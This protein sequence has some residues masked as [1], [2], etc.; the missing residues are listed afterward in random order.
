M[1]PHFPH[2]KQV[3]T[4]WLA[5]DVPFVLGCLSLQF[6]L[7]VRTRQFPLTWEIPRH[8]IRLLRSRRSKPM[9]CPI[10]PIF[11]LEDT[12]GIVTLKKL[13]RRLLRFLLSINFFKV[14]VCK[15]KTAFKKHMPKRMP[16]LCSASNNSYDE[17]KAIRLRCIHYLS[18]PYPC[19]FSQFILA[20]E[21]DARFDQFNLLPQ[22][23]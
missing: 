10:P 5:S 13:Y 16:N 23:N 20:L 19:N 15:C 17:V 8:H 6:A 1:K 9:G 14:L 18:Y 21:S 4:V 22:K 11:V 12:V 3:F 2:V 7:Q